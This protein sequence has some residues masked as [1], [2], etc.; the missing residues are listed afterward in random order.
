M[1]HSSSGENMG[2][3]RYIYDD[4][5]GLIHL[6]FLKVWDLSLEVRQDLEKAEK[7]GR[8]FKV[9]HWSNGPSYR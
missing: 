5:W 6:I 7:T 3:L 9:G 8:V 2:G 4:S 1:R